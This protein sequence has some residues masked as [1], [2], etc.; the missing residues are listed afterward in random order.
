MLTIKTLLYGC[1]EDAADLGMR[2]T[3]ARV[4]KK[5]DETAGKI[6]GVAARFGDRLTSCE[7]EQ[8]RH[9]ATLAWM[10]GIAAAIGVAVLGLIAN[11]VQGLFGRPG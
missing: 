11:A 8:E 4:E 9:K 6:D 5:C 3:L 10:R 1:P 7:R 2:G